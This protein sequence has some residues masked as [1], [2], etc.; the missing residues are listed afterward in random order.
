MKVLEK[1]A[2]MTSAMKYD[3][4]KRGELH[5]YLM[6]FQDEQTGKIRYADMAADLRGFNYDMETNE[7]ILPKTPNSISSGRHSYFGAAV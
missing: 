5:E 4:E 2:N 1:R 3:E 6:M 7:G